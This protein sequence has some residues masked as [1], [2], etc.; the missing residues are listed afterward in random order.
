MSAYRGAV[1]L[2]AAAVMGIADTP[3]GSARERL[4]DPRGTRPTDVAS[5]KT[6]LYA[7]VGSELTQY[8]VDV[9]TGALVR[10]DSV[11]LPANVQEAAL[12]PSGHHLY[13]G[14]S[15]RGASYGAAAA[16]A[17]QPAS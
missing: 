11:H 12:H 1:V 7:A 9:E 14:W 6:V 8:D 4:Q 10:R 5:V 15:S 17:G 2:L 3:G 13:V 16:A